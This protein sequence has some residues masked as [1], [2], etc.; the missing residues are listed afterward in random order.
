MSNLQ[1]MIVIPPDIFEKFKHAVLED[2]Q[3]TELD[4]NMKSILHNNKLTDLNKWHLYRQNLIK[5]SSMK[6][7]NAYQ[8][9]FKIHH[10]IKHV[11]GIAVQ[12]KKVYTKDKDTNTIP[13]K[14]IPSKLINKLTQTDYVIP[15][16]K[17]VAD[18]QTSNVATT[19]ND[20]V[21]IAGNSISSDDSDSDN[22]I[23]K[24]QVRI[25]RESGGYTTYEMNDGTI[26]TAPTKSTKKISILQKPEDGSDQAT[27]NFQ[28]RK[29][30]AHM[31]ARETFIRSQSE[32]G[33]KPSWVSLN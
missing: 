5:Y 27:L 33:R 7:K 25:K 11:E 15:E 16:Y 10:P 30:S 12:T 1:R 8:N 4:K 29:K 26:A 28:K 24:R 20:E 2:G 18:H 19:P 9:N 3:L 21:F 23:D 14:L 13:S 22:Y 17:G 6:R 31:V 32:R